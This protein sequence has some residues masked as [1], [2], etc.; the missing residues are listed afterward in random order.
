MINLLTIDVEDYCSLFLRDRLGKN[1]PVSGRVLDR[2][3]AMLDVISEAGASA[4]CFCLGTVVKAHPLLVK[5]IQNRGFE[6]ASHGM[7]HL[8]FRDQPLSAIKR[9]L[10]DA[11]TIIEDAAGTAVRGF[12]AP[13]FNVFLERP[14]VIEC[15]I[16]TGH[17]FD[18]SIFPFKGRRYGSPGS[19]RKPYRIKTSSGDLIEFPLATARFAGKNW[20]VAGGGYLRHFPYSISRRAIHSMNDDGIPATVYL[21]PYECDVEPLKYETDGL[22]LKARL[23]TAVFN[24]SQYHGRA[25][26]LDKL[27]ALVG[28][29]EF[30]SM[31]DYLAG[32][33]LEDLPEIDVSK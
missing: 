20:P 32:N 25:K 8:M 18:S 19:P 5:E 30:Q 17:D 9:D 11:K 33:D 26:T 10:T 27:S 14:E 29:F 13:A 15:I 23:K 12:R 31:G 21:H 1:A 22:S 7:N 3:R 6:V 28:D 16:E 24:A 2:A 4:T